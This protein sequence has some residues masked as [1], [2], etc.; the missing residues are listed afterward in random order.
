[1]VVAE[2]NNARHDEQKDGTNPETDPALASFS[3][4]LGSFLRNEVFSLALL[5]GSPVAASTGSA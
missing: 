2:G 5:L 4:F 3:N 1:L